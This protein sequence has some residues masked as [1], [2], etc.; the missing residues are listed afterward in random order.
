[1]KIKAQDLIGPALDWAVAT[2]EGYDCQF[3]DEVSGPW[4]V[5]QEGYLHNEKP[6][7]VFCPSTRWSQGG[8]L[9]DE[10]L[11]TGAVLEDGLC[12]IPEV[13]G[14]GGHGAGD[15]ALIAIARCYVAW[16][17]GDEVDVPEELL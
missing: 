16:K 12:T 5:P 17:L 1:M 7:S 4:L 9:L 6:L 8:L 10:M 14:R 2:C 11:A 13:T 15:T 3:D